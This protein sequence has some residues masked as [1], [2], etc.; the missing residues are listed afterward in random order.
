MTWDDY[1]ELGSALLDAYPTV[2]Y[3]AISDGDLSRLVAALPGFSGPGQAPDS[4][5][6]AAVR[7]AW[8]AAAEGDDDTGPFDGAG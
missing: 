6:L 4:S 2:N 3:M 8:I 5:S 7:F 1:Q